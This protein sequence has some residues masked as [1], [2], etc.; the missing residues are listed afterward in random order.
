MKKSRYTQ[1]QIVHVLQQAEV[2]V[3]VDELLRKYG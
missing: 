1:A 2:G 3:P